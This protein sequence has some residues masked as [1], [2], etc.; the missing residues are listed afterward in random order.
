MALFSRKSTKSEVV[1]KTATVNRA[2]PTDYNLA[3]VILKPRLTEKS[4]MQGDF[5]VYTFEV[6]KSA[7]KHSVAKAITATYKVTPVKINIVNKKTR[8]SMS[9][10]K[11]RMVTQKGY[12]KAYVYLKKGE[13]ISLI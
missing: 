10:T 5:S 12:K 3:G 7:T 9:K 4:V 8:T 1:E 2:L 13:T 11:G 6:H